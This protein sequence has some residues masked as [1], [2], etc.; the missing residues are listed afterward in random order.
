EQQ[1]M[2]ALPPEKKEYDVHP[3]ENL[4]SFDNPPPQS[5]CLLIRAPDQET[6]SPGNPQPYPEV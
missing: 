6:S 1:S 4:V 3:G 5:C 2:L